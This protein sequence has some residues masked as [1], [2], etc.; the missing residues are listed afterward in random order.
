MFVEV[1]LCSLGDLL[2]H[3]SHTVSAYESNQ[4]WKHTFPN[5]KQTVEEAGTLTQKISDLKVWQKT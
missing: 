3:L 5:P 1:S 2:F 4:V